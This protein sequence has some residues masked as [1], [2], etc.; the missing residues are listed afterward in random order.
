MTTDEANKII[1]EFE[2]Y[3]VLKIDKHNICVKRGNL[4]TYI[5]KYSDS[6]DR[7]IPAWES[8]ALAKQS[9]G[10]V[11][12]DIAFK[13]WEG[14]LIALC[15]MTNQFFCGSHGETIPES[16]AIVLAMAIKK[17]NEDGKY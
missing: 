3:K 7:Q 5:D 1:A 11:I 6:L 15:K 2:G 12:G 17:R 9:H 13:T 10:Y 8:L 4:I 16:S 14:K